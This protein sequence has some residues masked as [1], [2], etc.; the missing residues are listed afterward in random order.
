MAVAALANVSQW[1]NVTWTTTTDAQG[2]PTTL[3]ILDGVQ[4]EER[5]GKTVLVPKKSN[6]P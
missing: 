6:Q 2:R 1:T 4:G 5:N 3:L